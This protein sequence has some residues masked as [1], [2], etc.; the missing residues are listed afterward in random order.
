MDMLARLQDQSSG[1]QAEAQRGS[2]M[3]NNFDLEKQMYSGAE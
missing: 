3:I 2:D 1:L